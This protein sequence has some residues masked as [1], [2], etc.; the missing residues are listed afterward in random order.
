P[1]ERRIEFLH[2]EN[3]DTKQ[4]HLRCA[5]SRPWEW[6]NRKRAPPPPT[7]GQS[8]PF[9]TSPAER[10]S[11]RLNLR[12]TLAPPPSETYCAQGGPQAGWHARRIGTLRLDFAEYPEA[13][14][15]RFQRHPNFAPV[16]QPNC[17]SSARPHQEICMS[18]RW[19][20]QAPSQCRRHAAELGEAG[21]KSIP[22]RV[23]AKEA[24]EKT[25]M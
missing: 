16:D 21:D 4:A 20:D 19:S 3:A 17:G 23:P 8:P 15:L 25:V 11:G 18:R 6:A 10:S 12:T 14:G 13:P 24:I 1:P 7:Q 5:G 9:P 2:P 22:D